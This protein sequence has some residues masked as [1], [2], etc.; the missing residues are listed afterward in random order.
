MHGQQK[1]KKASD[2]VFPKTYSVKI[3]TFGRNYENIKKK[4]LFHIHSHTPI[5]TPDT[6][7]CIISEL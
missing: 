3:R 4:L 6:Q 5:L 1:I 7:F 2:I